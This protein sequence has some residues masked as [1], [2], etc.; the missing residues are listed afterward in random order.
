MHTELAAALKSV[1]VAGIMTEGSQ[2]VCLD[3][4]HYNHVHHLLSTLAQ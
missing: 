3:I 2:Q 1:N 4:K